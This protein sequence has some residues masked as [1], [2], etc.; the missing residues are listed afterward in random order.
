LASPER[1]LEL[2]TPALGNFKT[3]FRHKALSL[4]LAAA[5]VISVWL[6]ASPDMQIRW[7]GQ[8]PEHV[9]LI[10]GY[11]ENQFASAAHGSGIY[12]KFLD[13]SGSRIQ[14][15]CN[16]Y[17]YAVYA[18]SPLPVLVGNPNDVVNNAPQLIE[19]NR[20]QPDAQSLL[21][22]G[23]ST[24]L[25][26]RDRPTGLPVFDSLTVIDPNSRNESATSPSSQL[27]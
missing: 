7:R 12:L 20:V 2:A 6:C 14:F 25:A 19:A 17:F 21:K 24:V 26:I 10:Y 22:Q 8:K 11:W 16:L 27:K 1:N 15:C 3:S 5:V 4:V 13:F 23:V 18:I 9:A